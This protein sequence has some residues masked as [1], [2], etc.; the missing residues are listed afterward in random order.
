[1]LAEESLNVGSQVDVDARSVALSEVGAVVGA[2]G[3]AL[4]R[5]ASHHLRHHGE[6]H[7]H[8]PHHGCLGTLRPLLTLAAAAGANTVTISDIDGES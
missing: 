4:L 8:H 1:M 3:S 6:H 7:L 2:A 5:A